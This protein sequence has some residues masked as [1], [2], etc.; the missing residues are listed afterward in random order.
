MLSGKLAKAE[1][2]KPTIPPADRG[3]A[4]ARL[5]F[6]LAE[7][8]GMESDEICEDA[9]RNA[10]SALVRGPSVLRYA[11]ARATRSACGAGG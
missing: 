9:R 3:T 5:Y 8:T 1:R 6:R 4:A 2:G 11:S 7:V 10:P